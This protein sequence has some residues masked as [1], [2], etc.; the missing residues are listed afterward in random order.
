V[1][2]AGTGVDE[3][4]RR[5]AAT[6]SAESFERLVANKAERLIRSLTA[7]FLDRELAEDAA[8]EAFVQLY[9]H[10]DEV[11]QKGDPEPWLYRVAFNRCKDHRRAF[12]RGVRLVQRLVDTKASEAESIEW[13][14]TVEFMGVLEHLPSRQRIAAALYYDADFSVADIAAVMGISQGAVNSHLHRARQA[15]RGILEAE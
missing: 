2:I 15:L 8:Q 3:G 7:S 1:F 14:P 13:A 6:P 4:S 12:A 5:G 11:I 9:L 10:W